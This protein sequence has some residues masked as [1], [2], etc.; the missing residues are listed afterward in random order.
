MNFQ[1]VTFLQI[2]NNTYACFVF[3]KVDY[4]GIIQKDINC[5][6]IGAFSDKHGVTVIVLH[7]IFK[8]ADL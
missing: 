2:G 7:I 1:I 3:L 6:V 5:L 8:I 4:L